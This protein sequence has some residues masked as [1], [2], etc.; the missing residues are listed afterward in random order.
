MRFLSGIC[1][2][3]VVILH[4]GAGPQDPSSAGIR[5]ATE[6]LRAICLGA[7]ASPREHADPC[8]IVTTCLTR[9]EDHDL[10]N[11]GKGAALQADGQARVTAAY[12][13]GSSR[14]F[15][16]IISAP[17]IQNPSQLAA[18]LQDRS[19]RVLTVPGAE[20]WARACRAPVADLVTPARRG[21]WLQQAEASLQAW[22]TVGCVVHM[23]DGRLAAGTSTGGRGFEY[24]GRVSDSGTVAGNYASEVAAISCT[25]IGEEIVDDGLA[26]RLETL[27]STGMELETAGRQCFAAAQARQRAYGWIAVDA[28]GGWLIAHTTPAMTF[29]VCSLQGEVVA[30]SDDDLGAETL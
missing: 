27:C 8:S 15:S 6:A 26:V 11:A 1:Q 19:S 24:P 23:A 18:A 22:D 12:M 7:I 21:R 10:F 28:T 9:M 2:G 17:Y 3:G 14:R 25:G 5:Q 13:D 29:V 4:G 16:G 20:L 30:A